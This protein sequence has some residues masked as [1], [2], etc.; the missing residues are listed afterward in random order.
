MSFYTIINNGTGKICFS[1]RELQT[2]LSKCPGTSFQ[3]HNTEIEA[4]SY[5]KECLNENDEIAHMEDSLILD[6]PEIYVYGLCLNNK[7][8]YGIYSHNWSHAD[9]LNVNSSN[10]A[11]LYAIKMVLKNIH[12][13]M[14]IYT[15]K[16]VLNTFTQLI[17]QWINRDWVDVPNK[18]LIQKIW[19]LYS[20]TDVQWEIGTCD[21][22]VE[23]VKRKL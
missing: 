15:S 10:I 20:N 2:N 8:A 4:I 12:V 21:E 14:V 1:W 9:Y 11:E 3:K 16:R 17:P 18:K 6:K 7:A 22:V 19:I 23:L 5:I 13:P